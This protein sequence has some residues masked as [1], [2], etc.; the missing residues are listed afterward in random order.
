MTYLQRIHGYSRDT[1]TSMVNRVYG[2]PL[3]GAIM[4]RVKRAAVTFAKNHP[5]VTAQLGLYAGSILLGKVS[6][7]IAKR[8]KPNTILELDLDNLVLT[9]RP[10]TLNMFDHFNTPPVKRIHYRDVVEAL[11]LAAKDEKV[12]GLFCRLGNPNELSRVGIAQFQV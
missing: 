6:K 2:T 4:E 11:E 5:W 1:V 10:I 9:E 12:L 3:K 8:V 7:V